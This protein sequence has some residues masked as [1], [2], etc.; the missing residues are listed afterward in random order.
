MKNNVVLNLKEVFLTMSEI[1]GKRLSEIQIA[2]MLDDLS[3]Y[4]TPDIL[5][6]LKRCRMELN[7]FPTVADIIQRI[8]TGHPTPNEA[9]A[10]LPKSES[11]SAVWTEPMRKSYEAVYDLIASGDTI[12]ARSAFLEIY[13][14]MVKQALVTRSAPRWKLTL[15]TDKSLRDKATIMAKQKG[16]LGIDKQ[17]LIENSPEQINL[18]V[19]KLVDK[20]NRT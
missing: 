10:M 8:D 14:K 16:V 9:W 7:R 6:A 2:L 4:E 19:K 18:E 11:D 12:A 17:H 20:I 1:Y 5:K 15:G 13:D 3:G